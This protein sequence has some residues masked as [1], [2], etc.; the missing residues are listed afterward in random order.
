MNT[1]EQ[2]F[3]FVKAYSKKYPITKLVEIVGVSR[4]GYY[5][6]EKRGGVNVQDG[7]DEEILPFIL[8]V[9]ND[10]Q[11]TY[12]RKRIKLALE[13]E[14][15]MV[16]NEKR[17]ARLMRKYGLFCRIRQK[18]YRHY[19]TL[20]KKIPNILNR[21]FHAKKPGI[22]FA[23]DITYVEIKKGKRKWAY[24]CA[25]KDLF[26]GEIVSYSIS[27]SQNMELVF[28]AID[29]LKRKGFMKGALLHS[30]QGVQFTNPAYMARLEKMGITQS[31]SRRGNCWDNACIENFF[32][33]LKCEMYQ[34]TQPES[35]TEV[36]EAVDNYIDYYNN[37][38]IQIKLKTNPVN[39]RLKWEAA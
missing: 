19:S 24:V 14:H 21:N 12:G 29:G 30:D 8:K 9:F 1:K 2:S 26:N 18:K 37:K 39:Y 11:G 31:M 20:H 5:K 35:L 32:G 10:H 22:K 34:F 6:W 27:T 7:K 17:I 13:E 33:H 36:Y 28:Q 25:I 16:V 4:S 3:A 15:E 38:R 23:I